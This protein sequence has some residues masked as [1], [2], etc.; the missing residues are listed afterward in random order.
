MVEFIVLWLDLITT[1][2]NDWGLYLGGIYVLRD[3][4]IM[5]L[6]INEWIKIGYVDN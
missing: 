6:V 4:A 3:M 1:G 2:E 5:N